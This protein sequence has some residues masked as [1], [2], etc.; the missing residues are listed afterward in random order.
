MTKDA[1]TRTQQ[2]IQLASDKTKEADQHAADASNKSQLAQQTASSVNDRLPKVE[3]LVG[4]IDQYKA[5]TQTVIQYRPGQTVLSKDAKRALDEMATQL[6]NQRGY[7]LEV[8]GHSSGQ[9][10]AAITSSRRMA[11]SVVRYLVLNHEIPAYR[12]YVVGMGNASPAAEEGTAAK[13]SN[14][15]RVEISVLKNNLDQ[16]ASTSSSAS[17]PPK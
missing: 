5:G 2:G 8:H 1:D 9:G 3:N 12:I 4:G 11:D 17:A 13:R 16:L 10:Q 15:N 6:K 14:R 7:V